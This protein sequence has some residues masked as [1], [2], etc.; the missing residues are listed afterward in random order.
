MNCV[1]AVGARLTFEP[2]PAVIGAARYVSRLARKLNCFFG[3]LT[4]AP[5]SQRVVPADRLSKVARYV[6]LAAQVRHSCRR[7]KLSEKGGRAE[8]VESSE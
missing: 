2:S 6:I 5:P 8:I 4:R 7:R 1:Q 3:L